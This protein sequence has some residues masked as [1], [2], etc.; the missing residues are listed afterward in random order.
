MSSTASQHR[1][2]SNDDTFATQLREHTRSVNAMMEHP[3]GPVRVGR[4]SGS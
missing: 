4:L 2:G 3:D 1:I